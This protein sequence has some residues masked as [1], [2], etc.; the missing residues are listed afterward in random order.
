MY[1]RIATASL[2]VLTLVGVWALY[3]G[4]LSA[5]GGRGQLF[6]D[7]VTHLTRRDFQEPSRLLAPSKAANVI[8]TVLELVLIGIATLMVLTLWDHPDVPAAFAYGATGALVVGTVLLG[9]AMYVRIG[10]AVPEGARSVDEFG[11]GFERVADTEAATDFVAIHDALGHARGTDAADAATAA[12][13][14]AARAD[15]DR[16]ALEAWAADSGLASPATVA[17]RVDALADAG[18]LDADAFAF[19]DDRLADADPADVAA[20]A[21]SVAA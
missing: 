15:L 16:E 20:M 11:G 19:T 9:R 5:R 18:V 14:A 12:V 13:L 21:T 17:D 7:D 10:F 1:E 2:G 8:I 3:A 4:R 6:V